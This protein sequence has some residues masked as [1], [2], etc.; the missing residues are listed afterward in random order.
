MT[1]DWR[2]GYTSATRLARTLL[3]LA[4][5]IAFAILQQPS[6]A[7]QSPDKPAEQDDVIRVTTNLI[8]VRAVVT[9]RKGELVDDLKQEDFEIL[10]ND[11][12]QKVSFFSRHQLSGGASPSPGG[13]RAASTA[14]D[15]SEVSSPS[16]K[17]SRS[18]VIFVDTMHLSNVS[19]I[20]AKQQLKRFVNEQMSDH[21]MVAVVTPSGE[22]GVLQQFM[23]DRKMLAD[24]IDRISGLHKSASLFTPYL[25]AKVLQETMPPPPSLSMNSRQS[26]R[27]A[28]AQLGNPVDDARLV[29]QSIMSGEGD[30][31]DV[32]AR[33]REILSEDAMLRRATLTTLQGVSE[34]LSAMP[35]QRMLM[36]ISEGFTLMTE[37]GGADHQEF[38]KAT[39]RA[40]RAGVVI[41]SFNPQGL[42]VPAEFTAASPVQFNS[43]MPTLGASFGALMADSRTD[44]QSNLRSLAGDTGGAAFLNSNDV[45]GQ[46]KRMLDANRIYYALAYYPQNEADKK[47]RNLKVRVRDHPDYKVRT[48]RGYQPAEEKTADVA[49]TPQERLLRA[50]VAPLPST[51]IEVISSAS[52]LANREDDA[53][54]TLQVHIAGGSLTYPKVGDK[55]LM[56]G[57]VALLI[58]DRGGKIADKVIKAVGASF[59]P[60]QLD[61][62]K[63]DGYRYSGRLNLRPGLYQIRV[64]VRDLNGEYMGTSTAWIDVPDLRN[65][66]LVLSSLFL[67]KKD[68]RSQS[69]ADKK[70]S[71]LELVVGPGSFKSS[72]PIFYRFVVYNTSPA[73]NPASDLWQK[74]EVLR[75]GTHMYDGE[76][77][78]LSMRLVRRDATAMEV[79]GQIKLGVDPGVYSVQMM[80]KDKKSGQTASQIIDVE[81]KH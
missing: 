50:M 7:Q 75:A 57:E 15:Q 41:Y 6:S 66:K 23:R 52:F 8:Q 4:L 21:D 20:R 78:P 17:P 36:L 47:F 56:N 59:A 63:R 62:A 65:R 58:L 16:A 26:T 53:Q 81:I 72:E 44:Q 51:N 37:G 42:D 73:A 13:E 46:F 11:R 34:R 29:A 49:T 77:Q 10:E 43:T 79:G 24:A 64:G 39:S 12:P 9:D 55:Y 5:A 80:V 71:Q 40:V 60:D 31:G 48:Q 61:A 76:W 32:Y 3:C 35:G 27:N 18:I 54:V 68:D 28:P 45:N 74:T 2:V 19:M 1:K 25:A 14:D 30:L 70:T 67:G 22:L 38:T 69:S 33:A